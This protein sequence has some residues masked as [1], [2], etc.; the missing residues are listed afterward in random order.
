MRVCL[1][2]ILSGHVSV[3]SQVHQVTKPFTG[4]SHF[5]PHPM[6]VA[7]GLSLREVKGL[8]QSHGAK[9]VSPWVKSSLLVPILVF[10]DIAWKYGYL[11]QE[12]TPF[13]QKG[14]LLR[15]LCTSLALERVGHGGLKT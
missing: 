10:L 14:Y 2:L 1:I 9:Y 7:E 8:T 15:V 11:E 3:L 6:I 13:G 12:K 4:Y 5:C